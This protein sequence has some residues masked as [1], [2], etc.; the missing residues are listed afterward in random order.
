MPKENSWSKPNIPNLLGRKQI[1]WSMFQWGSTI[2]ID[3]H[4]SFKGFG[5]SDPDQKLNRERIKLV[6]QGEEYL[7]HIQKSSI[8]TR[9]NDTYQIRFDSNHTLINLIKS[10]FSTSLNYINAERERQKKLGKEKP[11]AIVP[12]DRAEYIDFITTSEPFVLEMIFYPFFDIEDDDVYFQ[13][14]MLSTTVEKDIPIIDVPKEKT[15]I[16]GTT[17]KDAPYKRNAVTAKKSIVQ[18]GYKCEYNPEHKDFI[19]DKTNENYVEAHHIIPMGFHEL[20]LYSIDVEANIVPLCC[21]CHRRI[22]HAIFPEKVHILNIL[23]ENRSKRLR[24][25]GIEL[26]LEQLHTFY[27]ISSK[28]QY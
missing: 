3:Y 24:N 10:N 21:S 23:F 2:P 11:F 16:T 28:N 17:R 25:C 1:D 6:Y 4:D 5:E 19:S 7:A 13:N 18:S 12:E 26:T 27:G 8:K 20:F 22:H 9:S 15:P 14:N